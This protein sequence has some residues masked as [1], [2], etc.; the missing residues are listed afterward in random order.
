MYR[1]T[2]FSDVGWWPVLANKIEVGLQEV[3]VAPRHIYWEND[4]HPTTA[5]RGLQ[6]TH[7]RGMFSL[8][9]LFF[10]QI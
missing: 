5:L 8:S 1:N 7:A 4:G 6:N 9:N 2:F 3:G 10:D